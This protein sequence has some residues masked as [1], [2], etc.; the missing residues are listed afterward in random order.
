MEFAICFPNGFFEKKWEF[1][2]FV[3][4]VEKRVRQPAVNLK[5]AEKKLTQSRR[6]DLQVFVFLNVFLV[7][8]VA[9][10]QT[11]YNLA[12]LLF[13]LALNALFLRLKLKD[14]NYCKSLVKK[15]AAQSNFQEPPKG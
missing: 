7:P 2:G 3:A 1:A 14:V 4:Y 15:I 8:P 6:G 11:P 12:Y 13:P 10:F 5:M 9:L